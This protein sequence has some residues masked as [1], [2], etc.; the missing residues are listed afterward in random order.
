MP[1]LIGKYPLPTSIGV[2]IP[3]GCNRLQPFNI[4]CPRLQCWKKSGFFL[5]DRDRFA[6]HMLEKGAGSFGNATCLTCIVL[7]IL[8]RA[9]M[10]VAINVEQMGGIDRCVDLRRAKARMAEKLLQRA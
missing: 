9:R 8:L 5:T 3:H 2:T 4:P 6:F 10:G 7:V 1:D